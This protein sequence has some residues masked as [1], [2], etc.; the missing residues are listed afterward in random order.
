MDDHFQVGKNDF[1]EATDFGLVTLIGVTAKESDYPL[2]RGNCFGM[3]VDGKEHAIL[4][5][6]YENLEHLLAAKVVSLPVKV[7][8]LPHGTAVVVDGRI[9]KGYYRADMC[10][11]CCPFDLLPLPQKIEKW[12]EQLAG[13]V[14]VSEDLI[15]KSEDLIIKSAKINVVSRKLRT[16]WES[17][18]PSQV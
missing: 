15:I 9:P 11:S 17:S 3:I 8:V 5:F 12:R 16:T 4:N 10:S 2:N 13:E 18:S 6:Y 7:K 14:T 1:R